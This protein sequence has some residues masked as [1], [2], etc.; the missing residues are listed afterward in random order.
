MQEGTAKYRI[1]G[2]Q[3]E[4]ASR[5]CATSIR[6]PTRRL[7]ATKTCCWLLTARKMDPRRKGPPS[8]EMVAPRLFWKCWRWILC[9]FSS[10]SRHYLK[11]PIGRYKPLV[12]ITHSHVSF[13]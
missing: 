9:F 4:S 13:D 11:P 6:S 10:I 3:Y 7:V 2:P 12:C 1:D 5:S 8:P